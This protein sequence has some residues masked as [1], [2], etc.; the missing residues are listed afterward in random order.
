MVKKRYR[1]TATDLLDIM[2][3]WRIN[4]TF[5]SF[6]MNSGWRQDWATTDVLRTCIHT[7]IH[8]YVHTHESIMILSTDMLF[9]LTAATPANFACT[10]PLF[11]GEHSRFPLV[12]D[13]SSWFFHIFK[14]ERW[15]SAH[16]FLLSLR[17][18]WVSSDSFRTLQRLPLNTVPLNINSAE[19]SH[20]DLSHYL[21]SS[22]FYTTRSK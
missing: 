16:D 2:T 5:Y 13:N 4:F 12:L 1:Y 17:L 9:G 19:L 21:H 14:T 6:L 8:T 18:F 7:Y 10:L 20:V 11:F 15:I 22:K 3:Y